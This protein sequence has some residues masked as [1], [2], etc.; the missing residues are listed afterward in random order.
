MTIRLTVI[1]FNMS[2]LKQNDSNVSSSYDSKAGNTERSSDLNSFM[3]I[4]LGI[5]P[6]LANMTNAAKIFIL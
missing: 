3:N 6:F 4:K 5:S 1:T 2:S